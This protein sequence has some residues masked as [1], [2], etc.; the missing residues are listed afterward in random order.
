MAYLF[1]RERLSASME[2]VCG[3]CKMNRKRS[4]YVDERDRIWYSIGNENYQLVFRLDR[5]FNIIPRS[6]LFSRWN[7]KTIR[8]SSY[9]YEI[10]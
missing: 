8:T 9:K 6:L 1:L 2:N 3:G 7:Y 4:R 10:L 5:T